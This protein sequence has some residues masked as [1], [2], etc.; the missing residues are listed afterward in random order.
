M[1]SKIKVDS[2]IRVVLLGTGKFCEKQRY[3]VKRVYIVKVFT[4]QK[5]AKITIVT[6][7]LLLSV[8]IA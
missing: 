6:K 3:L 5:K 7:M 2:V 4:G 1:G 8:W